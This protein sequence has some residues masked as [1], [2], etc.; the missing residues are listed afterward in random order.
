MTTA[1]GCS[2][3]LYTLLPPAGEAEIV[4]AAVP[5]G[6][7]VLDLGCGTGRVA[8]GLMALGHPVTAVDDSPEMLAHVRAERVCSRIED[9]RLDRRFDAVLLA[10][11]LINA[12]DSAPV[13]AAVARHLAPGGRA[14]VE[15]HPPA[16]FDTVEDGAG[17]VLGE[18]GIRLSGIARDAD[19]LEATVRYTAHGRSWAQSFTARRLDQPQLEAL[20]AG[21]GLVFDRFLTP[22]ATWF[23]ASSD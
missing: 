16:W 8:H 19:L 6:A 3:E 23:S 1:D 22:T 17:G 13:L 14:I 10:S 9:L 15:W 5:A 11:H 20:L 7:A 18:V 4:H 12:P 2:V 21:A